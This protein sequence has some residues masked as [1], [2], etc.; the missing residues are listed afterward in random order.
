MR[1]KYTDNIGQ[2]EKYNFNIMFK[3]S[4]FRISSE[5]FFV[6][7]TYT[8]FILNL[9]RQKNMHAKT[10]FKSFLTLTSEDFKGLD[11]YKNYF[12]VCIE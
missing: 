1:Q 8:L 2:E 7:I 12:S 6:L 11:C 9:C 5:V 3:L 10:C 4:L